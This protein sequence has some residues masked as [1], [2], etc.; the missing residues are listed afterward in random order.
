MVQSALAALGL[1]DDFNEIARIYQ[2][3][4][5][6]YVRYVIYPLCGRNWPL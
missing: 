1:T 2:A 6:D 3:A 4:N 5:L